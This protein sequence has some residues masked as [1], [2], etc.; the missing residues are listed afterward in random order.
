VEITITGSNFIAGSSV[1]IGSDEIAT[2]Y[3][4]PTQLFAEIPASYLSTAGTLPVGVFNPAP[5]GG[6]SPTTVT[7]TVGTLN[8]TPTLTSLSPGSAGAGTDA[9]T[10]TLSGAGF[11][12]G[13]QAF[14]GSTALATTFVSANN[15]SASVPAYLVA[16]AG[17]AQVVIVNP[18]PGGGAST[19]V[20]FAVELAADGGADASSVPCNVPCSAIPPSTEE[21]INGGNACLVTLYQDVTS[22]EPVAIAVDST[23][24]Y[25]TEYGGPGGTRVMSVPVGGGLATTLA[26]GQSDGIAYGLVESA[27]TL[28]W[29]AFVTTNGEVFSLP[30]DGGSVNTLVTA[31]NQPYGIAVGSNAVY[32]TDY[33]SNGAVVSMSLDG[34]TPTTI[35]SGLE[36]SAV[37]YWTNI[38]GAVM[39]APLDGGTP[40]TFVSGGSP[41]ALAVDSTNLY[42]A[43]ATPNTGTIVSAPVDGSMPN[44]VASEQN[45]PFT[46]AVDSNTIYWGNYG[47][48]VGTGS[49]MSVPIDGGTPTVLAAGQTQPQSIAVDSTSVYWT[50]GMSGGAVMK[51]TPK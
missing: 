47:G 5:G 34:G 12:A 6:F 25:W 39:S 36:S 21:C 40:T 42:I 30:L 1:A 16:S 13:A 43:N 11:V 17:G 4:S 19:A 9:F 2:S 38:E 35:A 26:S 18:T 49:V 32:W 41:W 22:D 20:T 37:V 24:V 15:V 45:N 14:F 29:P 46:I 51:L 10:L 28:Y 44:I 31:Q 27:A 8:P 7:I 23:N 33:T 50:T 48:G 3:T